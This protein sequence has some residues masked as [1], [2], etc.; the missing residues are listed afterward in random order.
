MSSQ[1]ESSSQDRLFSPA[2]LGFR[3][4]TAGDK[5]NLLEISGGSP[6]ISQLP[7]PTDKEERVLGDKPGRKECPLLHWIALRAVDAPDSSGLDRTVFLYVA[8]SCLAVLI[9]GVGVDF[10]P[11]GLSAR[12]C[13]GMAGTPF[14]ILALRFSQSELRADDPMQETEFKKKL[15][16]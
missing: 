5:R 6:T 14:L 1:R 9:Q 11:E 7:P 13:E 8:A 16:I 2:P 4:E 3:G 15:F 10:E 12:H